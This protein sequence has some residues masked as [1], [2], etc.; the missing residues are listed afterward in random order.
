MFTGIIEEKGVIRSI[1]NGSRS[2]ELRIQAG[3]VLE[4][5]RTGD[6]VCTSGIC[7]TVT[8]HG[9]DWFTADVMPETMRRTTLGQLRTGSEVNLERALR[10][11]DRLG[12]HLVSGHVDGTGKIERTWQE[13]NA[14]WYRIAAAPDLLRYIIE[15]GSVAIDGISLTV[16]GTE[17][18]S[19]TVSVIPHTRSVTALSGKSAGDAVN[20]ECDM[21]A[22]YVERL[23]GKEGSG[24]RIDAD[25]L[26]SNNFI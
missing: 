20:I 11:S 25:F 17:Q 26:A 1:R 8:G 9:P 16:A 3:I 14:V 21:I 22:K 15:K 7:L 24:S 19:F 13:E 4:G 23:T 2:S 18:N 10:L 6:S 12:G 5:M